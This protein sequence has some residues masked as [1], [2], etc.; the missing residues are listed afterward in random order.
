MNVW[1]GLLQL[2]M[3]FP[4]WFRTIYSRDLD[5]LLALESEATLETK[6]NLYR[7]LRYLKNVLPVPEMPVS[8]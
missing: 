8:C 6:R 5:K 2:V 7:L 1:V 3:M 4:K